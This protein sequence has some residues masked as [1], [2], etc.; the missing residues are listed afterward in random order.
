MKAAFAGLD[1]HEGGRWSRPESRFRPGPAL[2]PDG[3]DARGHPRRLAA[4][5]SGAQ[6][7]PHAISSGIA[8]GHRASSSAGRQQRQVTLSIENV[9]AMPTGLLLVEDQVPSSLGLRPRFVIDRLAPRSSRVVRFTVRSDIR[10]RFLLGPLSVR[11]T[12][13]FGFCRLDRAFSTQHQLTVTP[14]IEMLANDQPSRATG[15]A[16]ETPA[17]VRSQPLGRTTSP[18]AS[19][20]TATSCGA[21]IGEL[22]LSRAR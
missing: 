13:P 16:A 14:R 7:S 5:A 19:T 3:R 21:S 12:D 11:L 22:P 6:R 1:V 20:A 9:A 17:H 18:C 10:G 2:R 4:L 8:E 15:V